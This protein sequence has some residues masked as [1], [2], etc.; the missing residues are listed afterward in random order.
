MTVPEVHAVS[1]GRKYHK[2]SKAA[3]CEFSGLA[4]KQVSAAEVEEGG[5][6]GQTV[7]TEVT[8]I[9]EVSRGGAGAG[10]SRRYI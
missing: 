2:S 6:G 10:F 5:V 3:K 9:V 1:F 4:D 7:T 8:I